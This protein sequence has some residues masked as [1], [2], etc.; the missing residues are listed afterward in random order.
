MN[1]LMDVEECSKKDM[2]SFVKLSMRERNRR[3]AA[4]T[5]EVMAPACIDKAGL[6]HESEDYFIHHEALAVDLVAV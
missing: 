1:F 6:S 2:K 5:K 4:L 3:I